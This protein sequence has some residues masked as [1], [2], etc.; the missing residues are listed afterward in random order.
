MII[1]I[2]KVK[3]PNTNHLFN[4]YDMNHEPDD[5][6]PLVIRNSK[7]WEQLKGRMIKEDFYEN[8]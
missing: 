5:D 7:Y 3:S 8:S 4:K 6:D 2:I 1:V